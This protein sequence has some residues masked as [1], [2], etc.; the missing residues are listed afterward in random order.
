MMDNEYEVIEIDMDGDMFHHE[1]NE[2]SVY[3]GGLSDCEAYIRLKEG[4][5]M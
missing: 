5:Y 4:G 3:Q 1:D 2:E